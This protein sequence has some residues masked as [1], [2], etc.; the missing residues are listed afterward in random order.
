MLDFFWVAISERDEE[1]LGMCYRFEE[2][3]LILRPYQL[4]ILLESE[5]EFKITLFFISIQIWNI[6]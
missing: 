2:F 4:D 3:V 5:H 1:L 6:V